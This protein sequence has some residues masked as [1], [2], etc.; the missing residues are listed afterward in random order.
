MKP[1]F[2]EDLFFL[3]EKGKK[4]AQKKKEQ[5]NICYLVKEKK[6]VSKQ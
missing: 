5:K 2:A 1:L 4:H 3:K 6:K